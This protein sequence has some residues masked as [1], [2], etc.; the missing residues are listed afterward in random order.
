MRTITFA[1]Q[2]GGTG[3]STLAVGLAIA[4]MEDGER[5]V[6]V[7]TDPQGTV[8]NWA[9][10]RDGGEPGVERMLDRFALDRALSVLGRRGYTLAIIDTPGSDNDIVTEA[11]RLADLCLIP[12]RPSPADI[13]ATHPTLKAIRR[14]GR[15]FAF[16]LNQAPARGQRPTRIAETLNELGVL[17]LPYIALRN[18][19]MDSLAGGLAVSEFA[20]AGK[21]AAEIRA[22]WIWSKHRLIC[23]VPAGSASLQLAGERI[24]RPAPARAPEAVDDNPLRNIVLQS[25]RLAALPWAPWL[26]SSHAS[27]APQGDEQP[28]LSQ[29][30]VAGLGEG[31]QLRK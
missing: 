9:A 22:L 28:R 2:K 16:V 24:A 25:L 12:A 4:A 15:R 8:S 14:F 27:S 30:K 18:D 19:H 6:I 17:A 26:R 23:D 7:E 29:R 11:V 3:K 13:E 31:R 10:R 1:T 5:S 21:A 20:P